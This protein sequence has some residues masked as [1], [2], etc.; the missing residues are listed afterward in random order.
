M[1]NSLVDI[2]KRIGA[3]KL[4]WRPIILLLI[5]RFALAL[6]LQPVLALTLF[7]GVPD[8]WGEAGRFWPV[9]LVAIDLATLWL[10]IRATRR[11]GM[12]FAD[13]FTF[14]RRL[15]LRDLV[16]AAVLTVIFLPLMQF[17]AA[18]SAD[19]FY[20]GAP[21]P[22]PPPLPIWAFVF[23][24]T[25]GA[26]SAALA[27]AA[28]YAG[29]ALPRIEAMTGSPLAALGIVVAYW[30]LQ[31]I[32]LPL[33]PE[34]AAVGSRFFAPMLVAIAAALAYLRLRR[35]LP[36]IIGLSAAHAAQ[37]WFAQGF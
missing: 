8:P 33:D 35:L 17:G 4:G 3:G 6:V 20:A 12:A 37:A 15:F 34:P 36:I 32:A 13:L 21:P 31:Q 9:W 10:L 14:T 26:L 25:F 28:L 29:Y 16:I 7:R 18:L 5:A 19:L 24:L 2:G 11:E 22:A 1:S 23:A 27:E 30:M